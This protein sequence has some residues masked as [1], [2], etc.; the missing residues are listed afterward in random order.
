MDLHVCRN[1]ILSSLGYTL[2]NA[3]LDASFEIYL[4]K[5]CE[6]VR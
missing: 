3:K 5:Q 4:V 1:L 6:E 2:S